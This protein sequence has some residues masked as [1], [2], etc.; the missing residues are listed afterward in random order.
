MGEVADSK[1]VTGDVNCKAGNAIQRQLGTVKAIMTVRL[2][3][4]SSATKIATDD[5]HKGYKAVAGRS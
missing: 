4:T 3:P 5:S 1:A 2:P